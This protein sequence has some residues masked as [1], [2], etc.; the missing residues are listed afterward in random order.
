[1]ERTGHRLA[2]VMF[3]DIVGFTR[4]LERDET[5]T[6]DLLATQ[7]RLVR[8]TV[9]AY[10]GRVIKTVG[11]ALLCEFPSAVAAVRCAAEIQEAVGVHNEAAPDLPLRLRIGVHLGDIHFLEDDAI[12]DGVT[13]VTR[14]QSLARPGRIC[15]SR[16]VYHL[17]ADKIPLLM[18]HL[19]QVRL[20]GV[21]REIDAYEISVSGLAE[22]RLPGDEL[23]EPD[24]VVR[25]TGDPARSR[26]PEDTPTAA[27][28][29]TDTRPRSPARVLAENLATSEY[30]DFN[31]LKSLVLQEIK[32][33]GRRISVDEIR[34]RLPARGPAVERGLESLV[35]KGFLT[36]ARSDDDVRGSA[37]RQGGGDR[38]RERDDDL[39]DEGAGGS[40]SGWDRAL[41]EPPPDT[42]H[43][44][45]IEDYKD[46]VAGVAAKEKAGFRA[47]LVS[48][49]GVNGGLFLLWLTVAGAGFPW[50]L[51]PLLA[52]GIG[53]ASHYA[54]VSDR[55]HESRELDEAEGLTREQL[56]L[57]RKYAK[58]RSSWRGHLVSN[59]ATCVFLVSLNLITSPGFMWSI[60]PVAFMGIGL[61]THFPA[62]RA[63]ERRL[64]K[65]LRE[66]GARIGGRAAAAV[67]RQARRG[68]PAPA[69]GLSAE[70]ESIRRRLVT[71]I[72]AL[73]DGSPLGADFEP[74]LSDYVDQIRRLDQ[75]SREIDEIARGIPLAALERDLL[76]LQKQREETSS[77]KL[78]AE[79]DRSI[80]QIREQQRSYAELKHEQEMLRL[81]L[82]SS[83]NQLKQ[84]EI[85]LAR[86]RSVSSDQDAPSVSALEETS[87][88]LSRYLE[89]LRAGYR[90]LE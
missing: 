76:T 50:F 1:M 35:Q 37:A 7:S 31:E 16:D 84:M 83:L 6:L 58:N 47:H 38:P 53:L 15:V 87:R 21:A 14:L 28:T 10:R 29:P 45:L 24:G 12:G 27:D 70:A 26:A 90:E 63:R 67:G 78:I 25:P 49:L 68:Q 82:S 8:E 44:P 54:G 20:R 77:V 32:R 22:I 17:V 43:D 79:Y 75:T 9:E 48:Y 2:A 59:V 30:A 3:T 66:L 11:D 74:V 62:Y 36:R 41:R 65:R 89:D 51:I 72:D 69:D 71:V 46:H 13:V 4:M 23:D 55:M 18:T 40:R 19:G 85:D 64:R 88:E 86:M 61:L 56:R 33:A 42:S 39:D 34:G 60:F 73:P 81:R 52:W 5:G 57:Y 80:E